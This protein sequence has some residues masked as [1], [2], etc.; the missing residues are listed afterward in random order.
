MQ[1][2]EQEYRLVY[3]GNSK[4]SVTKHSNVLQSLL[5]QN[6]VESVAKTPYAKEFGQVGLKMKLVRGRSAQVRHRVRQCLSSF[7]KSLDDD[8]DASTQPGLE[9]EDVDK[10]HA[11]AGISNID[12]SLEELHEYIT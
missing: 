9:V 7:G 6:I 1:P 4:Q 10:S 12:G 8:V 11:N 3:V 2:R 5:N